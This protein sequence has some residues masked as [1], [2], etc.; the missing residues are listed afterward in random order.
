MNATMGWED[1]AILSRRIAQ[2]EQGLLER[3]LRLEQRLDALCG[4]AGPD[5][6]LSIER[7]QQ[8]MDAIMRQG[9]EEVLG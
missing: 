6:E 8:Q 9:D 4:R 2:V 1:L 7:C 5:G 3:L